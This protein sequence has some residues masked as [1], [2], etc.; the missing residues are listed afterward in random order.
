MTVFRL[1]PALAGPVIRF[2]M[3]DHPFHRAQSGRSSQA[4][5]DKQQ[6]T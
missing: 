3:R 1:F 6:E 4:S 5:D 2:Y